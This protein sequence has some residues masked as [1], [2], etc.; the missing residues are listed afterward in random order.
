MGL[1]VLDIL[2]LQVEHA[3][4]CLLYNQMTTIQGK[5]GNVCN[6]TKSSCYITL[7]NIL[8]L[9]KGRCYNKG[10]FF[11]KTVLRTTNTGEK[12]PITEDTLGTPPKKFH[13]PHQE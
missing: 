9:F 1:E 6:M 5:T 11:S 13:L 2:G 4:V 3:L 8:H 10:F 7:D 12:L